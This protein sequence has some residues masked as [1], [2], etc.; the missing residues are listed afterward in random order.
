MDIKVNS[1][2]KH[3]AS[4][5]VKN[6]NDIRIQVPDGKRAMEACLFLDRYLKSGNY[7]D[8]TRGIYFFD[9]KFGRFYKDRKVTLGGTKI[10]YQEGHCGYTE[11]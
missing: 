1:N 2:L 6:K 10:L 3:S 4:F 11:N 7:E 5:I 8:N 9:S